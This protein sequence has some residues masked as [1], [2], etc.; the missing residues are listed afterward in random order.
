[1]KK[2]FE[3]PDGIPDTYPKKPAENASEMRS[4]RIL[5]R[6]VF[7]FFFDFSTTIGGNLFQLDRSGAVSVTNMPEGIIEQEQEGFLVESRFQELHPNG[8]LGR[9]PVAI[10]GVGACYDPALRDLRLIENTSTKVPSNYAKQWTFLL[11]VAH[12]LASHPISP[13]PA[14]RLTPH[15]I[16]AVRETEASLLESIDEL[17]ES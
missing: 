1:M 6:R 12:H 13:A 15:E 2:I 4:Q 14:A 9:P 5:H 7:N 11:S 3:V 17:L 10:Y 8:I 16:S